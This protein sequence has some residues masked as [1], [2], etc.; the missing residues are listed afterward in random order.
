VGRALQRGR[1]P[2]ARRAGLE[3]GAEGR[4]G[5]AGRPASVPSAS[6]SSTTSLA[7]SATPAQPMPRCCSPRCSSVPRRGS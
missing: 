2:A 1:V 6:S 7:Q 5:R 3:R 4:A